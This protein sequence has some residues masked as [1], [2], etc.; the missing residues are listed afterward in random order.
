MPP[1]PML[2]SPTGL[3]PTGIMNLGA[4]SLFLGSGIHVP[5]KLTA[6]SAAQALKYKHRIVKP[7][8]SANRFMQFPRYLVF[9][10]IIS[11]PW[12]NIYN[13]ALKT[14]TDLVI[15]NQYTVKNLQDFRPGRD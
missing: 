11:G 4:A 8:N 14:S 13:E 3:F 9:A 12:I 7:A 2:T 5:E 6:S 15:S 10:A 1:R